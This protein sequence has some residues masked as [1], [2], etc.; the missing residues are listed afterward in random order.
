LKNIVKNNH[1]SRLEIKY[2]VDNKI[3]KTIRPFEK[4]D[5]EVFGSFITMKKIN[6][7]AF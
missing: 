1:I 7:M 3:N 4:L 2:G 6:V 5:Y